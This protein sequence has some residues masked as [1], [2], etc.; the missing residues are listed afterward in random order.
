MKRVF[1]KFLQNSCWRATLFK[2]TPAQVFSYEFCAKF[3]KISMCP[4]TCE[5]VSIKLEILRKRHPT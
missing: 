1:L 3:L 4:N 2:Y 5:W